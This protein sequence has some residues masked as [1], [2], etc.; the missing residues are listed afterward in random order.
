MAI[1]QT[2]L[3]SATQIF[4]ELQPPKVTISNFL[5]QIQKLG[6][7]S[8]FTFWFY[9]IANC[10]LLSAIYADR[11]MTPFRPDRGLCSRRGRPGPSWASPDSCCHISPAAPEPGPLRLPW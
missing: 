11:A 2:V 7:P 4:C 3:R 1:S 5:V 9:L 10:Y 8:F 6:T